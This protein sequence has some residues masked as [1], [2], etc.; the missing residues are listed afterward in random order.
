MTVI[1][2]KVVAIILPILGLVVFLSRKLEIHQRLFVFILAVV[3][4]VPIGFG[5]YLWFVLMLFDGHPQ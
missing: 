4:S 2:L 3:F 1:V 5:L